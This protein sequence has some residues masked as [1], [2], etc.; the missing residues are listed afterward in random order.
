[1]KTKISGIRRRG[2]NLYQ[3]SSGSWRRGETGETR[4]E[5][6][7][8]GHSATGGDVAL[9]DEELRKHV[10]L[11][12]ASGAGKST[13]IREAF[14]RRLLENGNEGCLLLDPHGTLYHEVVEDAARMGASDRVILF[15]P[16]GEDDSVLGFNPINSGDAE[17]PVSTHV[18]LVAGAVLKAWGAF[19]GGD[20]TPRISRWIQAVLTPLVVHRMSLL[21]ASAMISLRDDRDRRKLLENVRSETVQEAWSTYEKAPIRERLAYLEGVSNRLHRFTSDETLQLVLGQREHAL[22]L[23]EAMREGK[24]VLCNLHGQGRVA[25]EVMRLLGILLLTEAYRV[26]LLRK[27]EEARRGFWV[28]VDEFGR[29]QTPAVTQGLNELRKY[30]VFYCLAIQNLAQLESDDRKLYDA[31]MTN[32]RIKVVFGGLAVEDAK[33]MTEEVMTGFL[34]LDEVKHEIW[35]TKA[36]M[37]EE[38]REVKSSSSQTSETSS[39]TET[40]S[41]GVTVTNGESRGHGRSQGTTTSRGHTAGETRSQGWGL[42]LTETEGEGESRNATRSR[43][44]SKTQTDSRNE[45]VGSQWGDALA[46]SSGHGAGV[47]EA[48]AEYGSDSRKTTSENDSV[49]STSSH[50][51][52][53]SASRGAAH[54]EASGQ[55]WNEGEGESRSRQRSRGVG[56]HVTEGES[57]QRGRSWQEGASRQESYQEQVSRSVALAE[58]LARS[59]GQS[60]GTSRGESVAV[61]PFL[62]PVE[63]REL[64]SR[65][66][67]S[68][69]EQLHKALGRIKNLPVG[70]AVVKIGSE[71]PVE[72]RFRYRERRPLMP[73]TMR[74]FKE[75]VHRSGSYLTREAARGVIERR[76][77][78]RFGRVLTTIDVTVEPEAACETKTEVKGLEEE[79]PVSLGPVDPGPFEE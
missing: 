44:G 54:A 4:S 53:G 24:I 43:G 38:R 34:P 28:F 27:P 58:S 11:A 48:A 74:I 73:E 68:L 22:S 29:Y 12:G 72:M 30:G 70:T 57:R 16:A 32:C 49:G 8:L 19:D 31:V 14:L 77:R 23:A 20:S 47:S 25:D 1:M 41:G 52:G 45:T 55:V 69:T 66:Y 63:F 62:S 76:Q 59:R 50:S 33:V 79:A 56:V 9:G 75:E 39:T 67:V 60:H 65:Q 17:T 46:N 37:V 42:N 3:S 35:Q 13:A 78:E 64:S 61:V 21:E 10:L 6:L 40:A 5:P 18:S 36:R 2:K 26:G 15:D 7:S 71:A 51:S